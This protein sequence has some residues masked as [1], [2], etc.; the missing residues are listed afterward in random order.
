MTLAFDASNSIVMDKEGIIIKG[1]KI[2]LDGGTGGVTMK[3]TTVETTADATVEI[4]GT[5][6]TLSADAM[7]ELKAQITQIN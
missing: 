3:G 1:S 7:L 4:K 2:E 5:K 6:L